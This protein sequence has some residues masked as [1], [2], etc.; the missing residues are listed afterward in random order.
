MAE[1]RMFAMTIIDSDDFLDMPLTTQ[2][3]YFH[4]SMRADD[5]G[6]I[7]NPK[8][9]QRTI[10]ATDGDAAMLIAKKFIIPFETGVVVIKHWRINN[11]LRS[12]RYHETV[13][14]EEKSR[15]CIKENRAYTLAKDVEKPIGIPV[16]DQ[17]YT[18]NRIDKN[19]QDKTSKEETRSIVVEEE[20][21][22]TVKESDSPSTT[23]KDNASYFLEAFNSIDG[24]VK[25]Q[26]P[27]HVQKEYISLLFQTYSLPEID[28]VFTNL[29]NSFYLL[30]KATRED[31]KLFHVTLDWLIEPCNFSLVFQGKFIK[32]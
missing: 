12:D 7:N 28:T 31:G 18:E 13:Y 32:K 2:A 6:F 8:K 17:R 20:G 25:C 30:G 16:V 27:N 19:R 10:G 15:L 11:Y 23:E 14:Q 5:D 29:R 21:Y 3:L 22:S 24:V 9:I 26:N 1:R 4:L